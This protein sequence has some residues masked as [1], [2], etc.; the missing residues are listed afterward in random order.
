MRA[1]FIWNITYVLRYFNPIEVH[2]SRL[3]RKD[4]KG[5]PNNLLSY[6]NKVDVEN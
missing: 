6:V 5:I 1:K 4:P 3:L 2:K